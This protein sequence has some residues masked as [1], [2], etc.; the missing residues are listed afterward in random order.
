MRVDSVDG[1]LVQC[2]EP[3]CKETTIYGGKGIMCCCKENL[4]NSGRNI[5]STEVIY[6]CVFLLLFIIRH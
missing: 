4:C 6:F 5:T 1:P 3:T 2:S